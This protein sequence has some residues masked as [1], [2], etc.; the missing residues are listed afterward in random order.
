VA[1]VIP[2]NDPDLKDEYIILGAHFDHLGWKISN[3]DTVVYNGADDNASGTASI[4]EIGRNLVTQKES[5]GRSIIIVAFD[6]EES[7]LIG[8]NHF[9]KDFIVPPEKIKLMFSLDMVGM[10]EAHGGLDMAGVKRLTNHEQVIVDLAKKYNISI[11]K[12]NRSIE[13]RTDTAPFGNV[14]IPA[15]HA[16]TG[17]ESP[18]HKPEDEAG[19]LDFEGMAL[20]AN[21]IS[22]VVHQ[23]SSAE[24]LSKMQGPQEGQTDLSG[25]KIFRPGIRLGLG[26]SRHIYRAEFYEGKSVLSGEGG[27][28][29]F[30]R[31]TNYLAIQPEVLYE[32]KG[33]QHL[34]GTFRTHSITTP[35]NLL[36]TTP[37]N[38]MGQ[39]YFLVGGYYSYHFGGKV[40]DTNLDF[41]NEYNNQE[42]GLN[43]GFGF[44]VLNVQ[45]GLCFRKG[46]TSL[47]R[48]SDAGS[49][50]HEGISF[51]MGY[52]F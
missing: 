47:W 42:F 11:K 33:S 51:S 45:M 21:Y 29:A 46:L 20:V 16:F 3:G 9:L 52:F 36:I 23:L 43:F 41:Q 25:T 38:I 15:I 7:G 17:T 48:D 13:Q 18:Y 44:Q 31:A 6:G 37:D 49:V 4:I 8:S 24:N 26:S 39:F 35:L 32:T 40:S 28:F 50:T 27:V 12:A 2:G 5:L 10:Y 1:R 19:K 30:I 34:E 22:A 14:G